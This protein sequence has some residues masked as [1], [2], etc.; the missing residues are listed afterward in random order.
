[1]L[2]D[3]GTIPTA[4]YSQQDQRNSDIMLVENFR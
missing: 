1:M 2:I 3:T 4:L